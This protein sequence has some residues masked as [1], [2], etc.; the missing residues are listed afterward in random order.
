[1]ITIIFRF[2]AR[3]FFTV[4]VLPCLYVIEPFRKI[5]LG[6]C[7]TQRIGHL[8]GNHDL[9][10]RKWQLYGRDPKEV[11]ILA[12]WDPANKQLFKM[13]KRYLPIYENKML[14]RIFSYWR[15]IILKTRFFYNLK[16]T[17]REYKEFTLAKKTLEFTPEE[18]ARGRQVLKD[19]GIGYDDW[20]VCMHARD[21][22]YLD[23]HRPQFMDQWRTRDFRN[24]DISNY[25]DAAKFIA[26]QGGYVLRMGAAVEKPL[27][28]NL[29]PRIIDYATKFR[30]DFMD[31]YLS[32]HCKF[33]LGTNAGLFNVATIFDRPVVQVNN[34]AIGANP[35]KQT[36]LFIIKH[37]R[38]IATGRLLSI[39]EGLE[40]GFLDFYTKKRAESY[41]YVENTPE[42]ILMVT[43]EMMDRLKGVP[44]PEDDEALQKTVQER[45]TSFIPN[46]EL[47]GRM[48]SAFLKKYPFLLAD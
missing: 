16:W 15:P 29:D 1:M 31:I 3:V 27:P 19:I 25:L 43:R 47:A 7:Y 32:S 26:S 33:F 8:A 42:D 46:Y 9:T 10:L 4:I 12:G 17:D 13:L 24:S 39:R 2:F 44:L 34:Y 18:E 41:E 48:S 45:F 11:I 6:I 23:Q 22:I 35:Y 21:P 37:V 5:R 30:S 36:D 14:T 28:E 20:F 38:E 40:T